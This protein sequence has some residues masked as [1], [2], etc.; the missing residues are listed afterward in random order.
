MSIDDEV[1]EI[2]EEDFLR[3]QFYAFLAQLFATPPS[4][5]TLETLCKVE[6]DSTLM[7]EALTALSKTA[8]VTTLEDLEDEYSKLFYGMGQGGEI[9]PYASYYFSGQLYDK[10]LAHLRQD[11]KRIGIERSEENSEPEDHIAYLFEIM[12][13]LILGRFEGASSIEEQQAF[14]DAHIAPWALKLFSDLEAAESSVLYMAIARV[15]HVF[16]EIESDAFKMA[17]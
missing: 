13:G 5:S 4:E 10:A 12:H 15:A 14:F 8:K 2:P 3:A 11:M 9:L 1:N 16:M 6:G 17:A 7:G